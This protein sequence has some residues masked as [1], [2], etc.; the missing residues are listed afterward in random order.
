[1]Q[2]RDL[3]R[4]PREVLS[5]S[6]D[7]GAPILDSELTAIVDGVFYFRGVSALHLA[8]TRRF[9]EVAQWFWTGQAGAVPEADPRP[10]EGEGDPLDRFQSWLPWAA[11]NPAITPVDLVTTLASWIADRPVRSI[12]EIANRLVERWP[13]AS[14]TDRLL[15]EQTL[16][17]CIDHELNISSFTARCVASAGAP[18][19]HAVNGALSAFRGTR[20]GGSSEPVEALFDEVG[21]LRRPGKALQEW[22]THRK[23]VPGFG[24]RLYPGGDPRAAFLLDRIAQEKGGRR[25]MEVILRLAAVGEGVSGAPPNLDFALVALRRALRAPRGTAM[26]LFALGRLVGW[27]GHA[28]EQQGMGTLIRPRARYTGPRPAG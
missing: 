19:P 4:R 11:A 10:G 25:V 22:K 9:S 1:V 15:V 8:E 7:W 3:Q 24:H 28:L 5:A 26:A 6:L 20:H 23:G 21:E 12:D 18:L 17:L 16:I 14:R 13:G 2:R 27:I